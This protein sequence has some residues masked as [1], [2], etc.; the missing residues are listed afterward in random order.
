MVNLWTA[1]DS[2]GQLLY[3]DGM[4]VREHLFFRYMYSSGFHFKNDRVK[5]VNSSPYC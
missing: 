3:P 4:S 1:C 5:L 2:L